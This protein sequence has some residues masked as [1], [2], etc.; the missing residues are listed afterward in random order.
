MVN[1]ALNQATLFLVDLVVLT[2][3]LRLC[4]SWFVLSR[5]KPDLFVPV[6]FRFGKKRKRPCCTTVIMIAIV[7]LPTL[8]SAWFDLV[9]P[10][11]MNFCR[12]SFVFARIS[13]T[14]I[15]YFV[16]IAYRHHH[17]CCHD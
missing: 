7:M 5:R 4:L 13:R 1:T 3:G 12:Q 9:C 8:Y 14:S 11:S 15:G 17:H 10:N 16:A 2:F 6:L